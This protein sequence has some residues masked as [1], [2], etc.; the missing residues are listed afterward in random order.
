MTNTIRPT[1]SK[2]NVFRQICNLI[3][4]H[5]V[6]KLARE[7]DVDARKYSPWSHVVAMC[8][9]Q[10]SHS[11][12]LNDVCDALQLHSGPLSSIRGATAPSRNGLS[13]ANRRR[14]AQLAERLFWEVLGE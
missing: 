11:I 7:V 4:R 3:P 13:N 2:F 8:Y 1:A 10:M 9:A 14:P 6:P 5:L 12:S